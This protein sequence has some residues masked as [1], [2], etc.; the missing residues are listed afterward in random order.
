MVIDQ[1]GQPADVIKLRIVRILPEQRI[2]LRQRRKILPTE[3]CIRRLAGILPGELRGKAELDRER[4]TVLVIV[5][6]PAF[7]YLSNA[8]PDTCTLAMGLPIPV[9]D[10]T[11]LVTDSCTALATATT[12]QP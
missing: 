2:F 12:L 11:A 3:K 1:A 10:S 4:A 7:P 6:S 8:T 5:I 9:M